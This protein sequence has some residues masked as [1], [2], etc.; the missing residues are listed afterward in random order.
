MTTTPPAITSL[1]AAPDPNNRATFNTL[2]YPWSAA[3][4]TFGTQ[5]SAVAANVKANADEVIT[6]TDAVI[7]A[8]LSTAAANATT[9]STAASTATTQAGIATTKAGEANASAIAAAA[10]VASISGGPV[11]SVNGM[12]GVVTGVADLTSTQTL[13]NKTMSGTT[14]DV[15]ARSL[16]SATTTVAVS[17]AA[18]PTVGQV[19]TATSGTAATW[20]TPASTLTGDVLTTSRSLSAPDWLPCDGSLYLNASYPALATEVGL[21]NKFDPPISMAS[22][23]ASPAGGSWGVSFS[24]DGVYL[25]AGCVVSPYVTLYK[26]GANYSYAKLANPDV[27]P[28]GSA[29]SAAFSQDGV[30][31][32][33]TNNSAAPYI[34]IYKRTGDTF[35]KLANPATL[36]DS[37]MF[38]A[39][40]STDGTYLAISGDCTGQIII[41]KRSGDTFTK[42]SNP[43]T[44]PTDRSEACAFSKDGVYLAVGS[45]SGNY[46]IIYKRSGDTF[47]SIQNIASPA[48]GLTSAC[49]SPDGKY[50]VYGSNTSPYIFIYLRSGD[51]FT[52]QSSPASIPPSAQKPGFVFSEDS[53]FLICSTSQAGFGPGI[54]S[55]VS[56]VFTRLTFTTTAQTGHSNSVAIN[57]GIIALTLPSAAPYL[58]LYGPNFDVTTLFTVPTIDAAAGSTSFIKT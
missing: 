24:A 42:L 55:V 46:G 1:P 19:L 40:F 58:A 30:Y 48:A 49:F 23:S 16:K 33:V 34:A 15:E 6:A 37:A 54:Y 25:A 27:F 53:K 13:T 36:P 32:A 31:L 18:A 9:A 41:Y 26:R 47:T 51:V 38:S 29:T 8:G 3:L 52:L 12:T 39:S 20:Q 17:A 56:N 21:I 57:N 45:N 11:A 10:S 4:P 43:A 2:A 5:V 50:L 35:T 28:A 14:N 22:P 44:L 7:A